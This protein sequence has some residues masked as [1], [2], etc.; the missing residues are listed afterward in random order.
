M[1]AFY[2]EQDEE[3]TSVIDRLRGSDAEENV[4]VVPLGS[5]LLQSAVNMRLLLQEAQKLEKAVCIVTTDENGRMLAEKVGIPVYA[6]LDEIDSDIEE[7]SDNERS[8]STGL[9]IGTSSYFDRA[10]DKEADYP[11]R[12]VEEEKNMDKIDF[13]PTPAEKAV[14]KPVRKEPEIRSGRPISSVD[15]KAMDL[16]Q[17]ETFAGDTR[18]T[19]SQTGTTHE[20]PDN[21]D[22]SKDNEVPPLNPHTQKEV[23]AL[24]GKES[25]Q[26]PAVENKTTKDFYGSEASSVSSYAAASIPTGATGTSRFGRGLFWALSGMILLLVVFAGVYIFLPRVQIE[27]TPVVSVE[28]VEAEVTADGAQSDVNTVTASIPLDFREEKAEKTFTFEATGTS[29]SENFKARGTVVIY[30]NYGPQPQPLVATTRLLTPDGKLF[31]LV[32]RVT[33]PGMK[34][35][36]GKTVPGEVRAEVIADKPGEEYN[37]GPSE[38]TIPGFKGSP[39]YGKFTAKSDAPMVGGSTKGGTKTVVTEEDLKRAKEEAEQKIKQL[40]ADKLNEQAQREGKKLLPDAWRL[41]IETSRTPVTAGVAAK[42]FDYEVKAVAQALL[43]DP[44]DVE[45]IVIEKFKER[46]SDEIEGRYDVKLDFSPSLADFDKQT[47]V[48]RAR[49][50]VSIVPEIDTEEIRERLRGKSGEDIA[51]EFKKFSHIRNVQLRY[52]PGIL[53]ERM[54][55]YK[56]SITVTVKQDGE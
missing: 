8:D 4:F 39:K 31:R 56:N 48:L 30:N 40:L 54:P 50:E 17:T 55:W 11:V 29:T 34:T 1:K 14:E 46:M 53:S 35:V 52:S 12:S 49:A 3:I 5:T 33:V 37:I 42:T 44:A 16:R 18:Q 36:D 25:R 7:S 27:L 45:K 32:K 15:R 38:F 23:R 26:D 21:T 51:A 22:L 2:I 6:S 10:A 47:L 9:Q 24:F 19:S 28:T 20:N 43:F 41:T 13:E